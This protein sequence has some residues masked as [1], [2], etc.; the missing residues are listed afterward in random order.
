MLM[1]LHYI[2]S[3]QQTRYAKT[4]YKTVMKLTSAQIRQIAQERNLTTATVIPSQF[5]E[6]EYL[7]VGLKKFKTAF[8]IMDNQSFDFSYSHT[9]DAKTDKT[10]YT[11]PKGF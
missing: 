7:T 11:K 1:N 3:K 9:Y 8:F 2:A 5:A 6:I 10:T 4:L